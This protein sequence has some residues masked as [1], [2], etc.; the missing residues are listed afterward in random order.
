MPRH[1]YKRPG[2]DTPPQPAAGDKI[3]ASGYA[4]VYI[5]HR[6]EKWPK[7][8]DERWEIILYEATGDE[9]LL[10]RR[11]IYGVKCMVWRAKDG[12]IIAQSP[13]QREAAPGE[14]AEEKEKEKKVA[15]VPEV[16]VEEKAAE[17]DAA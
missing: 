6:A 13:A 2:I 5:G 11:G 15:K 16:A 9:V 10:G 7:A 1:N 3:P 4:R 12:T 14:K 17:G 8:R